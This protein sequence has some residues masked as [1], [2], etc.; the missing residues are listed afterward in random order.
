MNPSQLF[1]A[2][3]FWWQKLPSL[4]LAAAPFL[5]MLGT[6]AI[7][8]P[9]PMSE[10]TGDGPA[11]IRWD[12]LALSGLVY[13]FFEGAIIGQLLA[14]HHGKSRGPGALM[15]FSLLLLPGLLLINAITYIALVTGLAL[16]ILPGI[17]IFV[18]LSLAPMILAAEQ[19]RPLLAIRDSF[20]RTR[21]LQLGMMADVMLLLLGYLG[22]IAMT[23]A[24]AGEQP[25]NLA[26]VGFTAIELLVA[27]ALEVLVFHYYLLGWPRDAGTG[28]HSDP[29]SP[30]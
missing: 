30:E 14:L 28:N 20:Q 4:M 21:P 9:Q 2:L 1:P 18:R 6:I 11:V 7:A 15:L 19:T 5:V 22:I 24:V 27:L 17:W 25:G 16:F 3:R 29:Q 26:Q 13:T 8:F 23:L 12:I 10:T